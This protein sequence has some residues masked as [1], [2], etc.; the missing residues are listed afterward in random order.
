MRE[1]YEAMSEEYGGAPPC[2]GVPPAHSPILNHYRGIAI[3]VAIASLVRL[4]PGAGMS[5]GEA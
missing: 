3:H 5:V 1:G 4:G 2:F